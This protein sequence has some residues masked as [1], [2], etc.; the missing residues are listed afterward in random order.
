LVT[1]RLVKPQSVSMRF[2]TK[3]P[4]GNPG[5]R[6]NRY[7]VSTLL[8]AR[9]HPPSPRFVPLWSAKAHWNTPQSLPH[10]HPT[11]PVSNT[12]PHTLGQQSVSTGC[13]VAKIGRAH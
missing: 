5:I 12:S 6:I 9:K 3:K 10:Q 4:T 11:L 7:V 8:L 1:A 13:T 2:C